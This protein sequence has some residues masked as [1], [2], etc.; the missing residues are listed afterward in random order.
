[1]EQLPVAPGVQTRLAMGVQ[2]YEVGDASIIATVGVHDAGHV[3][4]ATHVLEVGTDP[5]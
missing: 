5:V 2:P 3:P 1:V 4:G